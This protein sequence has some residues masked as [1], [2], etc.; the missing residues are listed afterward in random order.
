MRKQSHVSR[1]FTLIELLV[2][3]AIIAVLISILLP[4]LSK[5]RAEGQMASCGMNLKLVG[6]GLLM[7]SEDNF[8]WFAWNFVNDPVDGPKYPGNK[9]AWDLQPYNLT[10][11]F[12]KAMCNPGEHAWG[13]ADSSKARANRYL[14]PQAFYCPA[15]KG[16]SGFRNYETNWQSWGPVDDPYGDVSYVSYCYFGNIEWRDYWRGGGFS[17]RNTRCEQ[18]QESVLFNDTIEVW[19]DIDPFY[20]IS[21]NH[22]ILKAGNILY[23][24]GHVGRK[25]A[26]NCTLKYV[27]DTT[28]AWYPGYAW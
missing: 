27:T 12:T 2:V 11:L 7:Y 28:H 5:A 20:N 22:S 18:L 10:I 16:R 25:L 1:G 6:T 21:I 24:D 13:G 15:T 26:R 17:P 19:N 14:P 8:G 4:A 23:G 3:V 9:S